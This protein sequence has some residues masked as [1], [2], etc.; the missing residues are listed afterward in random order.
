MYVIATVSSRILYQID[1]FSH[2]GDIFQYNFYIWQESER[3]QRW[4]V[5]TQYDI[6]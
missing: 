4:Y 5:T 2:W 3:F 6:I 1:I